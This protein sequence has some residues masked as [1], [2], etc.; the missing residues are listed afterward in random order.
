MINPRQSIFLIGAGG[1]GKVI[2]EI[3]ESLGWEVSGFV[4][5]NPQL[6]SQ[7]GYRVFLE[8]ADTGMPKEAGWVVSIGNNQTRKKLTLQ[9]SLPY[10]A[11]L[12]PS[13][14]LSHRSTIGAGTVAMAGVVVNSSTTIGK[15][16]ILNSSCS[17]DH[18]CRLEDFVHIAPQ[19]A[20]AG[21]VTIGEGSLIGIGARVIPG[22]TIGKW[23]TIG[24]GA[25]VLTD[26]PDG[27]T[28]VGVPGKIL[29]KQ[30]NR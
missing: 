5:Q 29:P 20:I 6:H 19:T 3:A 22:V 4:D 27:A 7:L 18:D 2:A 10:R 21:G 9:Y 24:A 12:H 25:V 26:V 11:L 16:C 17:I 15:H 13:I 28:V 23:C 8:P 30:V 1:H 14:L